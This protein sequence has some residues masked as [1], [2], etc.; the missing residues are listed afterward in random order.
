MNAHRTY[1]DQQAL[2]NAILMWNFT[3]PYFVTPE[4]VAQGKHPKKNITLA[5]TCGGG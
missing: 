4:H 5:K 1:G 3:V 2:Q